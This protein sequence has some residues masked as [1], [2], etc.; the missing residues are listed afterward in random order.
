[1][2]PVVLARRMDKGNFVTS[3]IGSSLVHAAKNIN[4]LL[5]NLATLRL[6]GRVKE[7]DNGYKLRYSML[8]LSKEDLKI[9]VEDGILKMKGDHKEEEEEQNFDDEQWVAMSYG[10]YYTTILLLEDAKVDEIKA[11]MKDG[12]LTIFIPRTEAPKKDVK[13]IQIK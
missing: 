10:Y 4:K 11:E 5:E 8:G 13:E 12:V 9:T 1:M 7:Q 2:G 6:L 3:G